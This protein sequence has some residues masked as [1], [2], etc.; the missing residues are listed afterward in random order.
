MHE[1]TK[2]ERRV[3]LRELYAGQIASGSIGGESELNGIWAP[4]F[5]EVVFTLADAMA[6]EAQRRRDSGI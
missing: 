3:R 5:V 1:E 4:G 2:E 6:V